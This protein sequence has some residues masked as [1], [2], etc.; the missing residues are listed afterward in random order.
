MAKYLIQA[1]Y[2]AEGLKGVI[3]DGGTGRRTAIEA[4][5]KS[6]GGRVEAIYYAFGKSDV[7]VIVDLPGH[8]EMAAFALAAGSPGTLTHLKTTVLMTPEEI[9]QAA[10]KASGASYRAP[11][12]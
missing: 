7:Y 4:A 5:M 10:K 2:S 3:K 12:H 8:V 6:L 9:D 11:G 1:G